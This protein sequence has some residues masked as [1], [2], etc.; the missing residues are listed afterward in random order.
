M[1]RRPQRQ[2]KEPQRKK[3]G[4]SHHIHVPFTRHDYDE[5]L[6]IREQ[7]RKMDL[8]L[9]DAGNFVQT[10]INVG[11]IN[12]PRTNQWYDTIIDLTFKIN[13]LYKEI[14]EEFERNKGRRPVHKP[15]VEEEEEEDYEDED[16]VDDYEE[17]SDYFWK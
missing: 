2:Q 16:F 4:S 3:H 14:R 7:I 13:N 9:T 12:A 11:Y 17:E 6:G 5:L 15:A 8:D 10:L 1:S